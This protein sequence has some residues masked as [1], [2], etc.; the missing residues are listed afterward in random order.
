MTVGELM[1]IL[2]TYTSSVEVSVLDIQDFIRRDIL[3][4]SKDDLD[5]QD[6]PILIVWRHEYDD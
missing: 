5:E 2:S 1:D 4:V 6:Q 3:E